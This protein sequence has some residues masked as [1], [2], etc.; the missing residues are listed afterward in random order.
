M[1]F[2]SQDKYIKENLEKIFIK[3]WNWVKILKSDIDDNLLICNI[4]C[5]DK[6]EYFIKLSNKSIYIHTQYLSDKRVIDLLK[7]KKD[8]DIKIIVWDNQ[9][10]RLL[11]DFN[12]KYKVIKKFYNHNKS[13]LIDDKYLIMWSMNLS[14]NSL[15]KNREIW[16][17]LI[18]ISLISQY[19]KMFE[20]DW[21]D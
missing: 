19:K 20:N 6:I 16:V 14:E 4:D 9:D 18:D 7:S 17:L 15:D 8:L 2:V 10:E 5:R 11:N 1:Y 3:D 13:I 12:W 21:N